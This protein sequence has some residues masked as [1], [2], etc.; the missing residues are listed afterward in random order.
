MSDAETRKEKCVTRFSSCAVQLRCT[1]QILFIK[2]STTSRFFF[3]R[4]HP[5]RSRNVIMIGAS[6]GCAT[7]DSAYSIMHMYRIVYIQYNLYLT[8]AGTVQ[9]LSDIYCTVLYCTYSTCTD[10]H[11]IDLVPSPSRS[12]HRHGVEE[13]NQRPR[14]PE[15]KRRRGASFG[16]LT[17]QIKGLCPAAELFLIHA[18]PAAP[19]GA[20]WR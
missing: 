15:T 13:L 14:D 16:G 4:G 20:W 9:S 2:M 18:C 17:R 6:R 1:T 3:K 12:Q 19:S 5:E 8:F 11:W 7:P 10:W